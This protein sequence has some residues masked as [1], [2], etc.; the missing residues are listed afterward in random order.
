MLPPCLLI[1]FLIMKDC[2]IAI[3]SLHPFIPPLLS[4]VA[5]TSC[6]SEWWI[7]SLPDWSIS[8]VHLQ[9]VVRFSHL[10]ILIREFLPVVDTDTVVWATG[11]LPRLIFK[12]TQ[13]L[14][15]CEARKCGTGH[16][17]MFSTS[18]SDRSKVTTIS[19][20]IQWCRY[21]HRFPACYLSGLVKQTKHFKPCL[22][23]W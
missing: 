9:S 22:D 21:A 4:G 3:R 13:A 16:R 8:G 18:H 17:W 6:P 23:A 15:I 14:V 12:S 10:R 11:A 5:F 19:A 2:V 7:T 1:P 20:W